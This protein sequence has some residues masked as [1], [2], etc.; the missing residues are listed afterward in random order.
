[1][2]PSFV[3]LSLVVLASPGVAHAQATSCRLDD[4]LSRVAERLLEEAPA[5]TPESLLLAARREG[6]TAPVVRAVVVAP[7]DRQRVTRWLANR[8]RDADGPLI[9][10]EARDDVHRLVLAATEA[11]TMERVGGTVIARLAPGFRDPRL[12][13]RTSD[14]QLVRVPVTADSLA[15]GVPLPPDV[16][17]GAALLQLVADGPLGPRPVAELVGGGPP[18]DVI[19]RRGGGSDVDARVGALRARRDASVLRSNRLLK[20]EAERHAEA[21]CASGRISHHRDGEDPE[22]RLRERGIVS[23]AVGETIA[24]GASLAAAM[25]A[26]EAS[27]SHLATL[28]D[29]RFTDVGLG[30]AEDDTGRTCLVV[31]LSS[32]PRFLGR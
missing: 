31:L 3:V 29:R 17:D 23:R 14:G 11:A 21:V 15:R 4:A 2:V 9:C 28:T 27:P 30:T 24:R 7:N 10:G 12:I 16:D 1:M 5:L 19:R 6:A 22:S 25:D 18:E 13:L 8:A 32:W 20:R 26:L